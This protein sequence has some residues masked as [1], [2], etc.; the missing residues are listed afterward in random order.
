MS[1][2]AEIRQSEFCLVVHFSE[3]LIYLQGDHLLLLNSKS[4][5]VNSMGAA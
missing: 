5:R 3:P 1:G 2:I 4:A